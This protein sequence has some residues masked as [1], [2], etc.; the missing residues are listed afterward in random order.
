MASHGT[1]LGDFNGHDVNQLE[2][3]P[4]AMPPALLY[5]HQTI[6]RK[7]FALQLRASEKFDQSWLQGA[8]FAWPL[9]LPAYHPKKPNRIH[10]TVGMIAREEYHPARHFD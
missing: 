6:W 3:N 7:V 8:H 9:S 1:Y 2:Q 4:K 10:S 5:R